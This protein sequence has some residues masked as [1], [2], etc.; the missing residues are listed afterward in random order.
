VIYPPSEISPGNGAF[1]WAGS[2]RECWGSI[3]R[4][5]TRPPQLRIFS[6]FTPTSDF[7][8]VQVDIAS[9]LSE[10]IFNS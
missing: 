10:P 3:R 6:Y 9:V 7:T 8:P 5:Y 1:L 4:A 2:I